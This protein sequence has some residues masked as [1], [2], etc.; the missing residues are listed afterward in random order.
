M[1]KYENIIKEYIIN[2][3]KELENK[4][5]IVESTPVCIYCEKP[6]TDDFVHNECKQAYENEVNY[7]E[8]AS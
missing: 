6:I 1:N 5:Y 8:A 3:K 2:K 4:E 7:Y